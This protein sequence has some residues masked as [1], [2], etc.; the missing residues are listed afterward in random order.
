MDV[1]EDVD[2]SVILAEKS[3]TRSLLERLLG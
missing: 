1:A 3:Q 2:C